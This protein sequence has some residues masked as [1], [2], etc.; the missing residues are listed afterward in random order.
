[1]HTDLRI[2]QHDMMPLSDHQT[3]RA[4]QAKAA[5][6]LGKI[7]CFALARVNRKRVDPFAIDV[8]KQQPPCRRIPHRRFGDTATRVP[9]QFKLTHASASPAAPD[10]RP[11]Y[12]GRVLIACK[13]SSG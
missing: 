1:Q 2:E 11:T 9:G 4:A 13:E 12:V 3:T 7:P 6:D 5:D 10:Y 8:G